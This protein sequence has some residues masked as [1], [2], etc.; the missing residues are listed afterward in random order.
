MPFGVTN[1]LA[2]LMDLMNWV[3]KPFLD[4]FVSMSVDDI[5]VN[6]KSF[7]E[8]EQHLRMV[9]QILRD[10]RLYAKLK[11]YEFWLSSVTFLGQIISEDGV[12]VDPHKIKA[13][14]N[15]SRSTNV[16]KV[17]SFIGLAEYYRRFVKYFSKIATPLTQLRRKN[18][19]FE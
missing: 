5:L 13:I 16:T 11:K 14:V 10:R 3:F 12:S 7:A 6:S 9:L 17:K 2:A 1:A 15:W 8:H 18:V 4:K 19:P